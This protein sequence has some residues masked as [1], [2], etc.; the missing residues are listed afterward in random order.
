M[1]SST[2][3][4]NSLKISFRGCQLTKKRSQATIISVSSIECEYKGIK[5]GFFSV[6]LN[7]LYEI[8]FGL[9]IDFSNKIT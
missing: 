5:V 1:L 4:S 9:S 6:F 3:A 7:I 2:I 8:H